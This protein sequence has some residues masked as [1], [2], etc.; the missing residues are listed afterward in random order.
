MAASAVVQTAFTVVGLATGR[1]CGIIPIALGYLAYV[2]FAWPD[3]DTRG[4]VGLMPMSI[5]AGIIG[6]FVLLV[7]LTGIMIRDFLSFGLGPITACLA[8]GVFLGRR[9]A[10]KHAALRTKSERMK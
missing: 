7:P 10:K 2:S 5:H 1:L 3:L 6:L 4:K 9:V 8:L